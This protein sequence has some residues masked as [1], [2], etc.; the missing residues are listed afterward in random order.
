MSCDA[1]VN[2]CAAGKVRV[3]DR[4]AQPVSIHRA[5]VRVRPVPCSLERRQVGQRTQG[6]LCPDHFGFEGWA[7]KAERR[8]TGQEKRKETCLENLL[9]PGDF[10]YFI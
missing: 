4:E 2:Q 10:T 5:G 7:G 6:E 9:V 1:R 3:C 8:G